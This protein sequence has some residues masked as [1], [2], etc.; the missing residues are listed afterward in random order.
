MTPEGDAA[1][2]RNAPEHTGQPGQ[3]MFLQLSRGTMRW[4]TMILVAE[5]ILS[6]TRRFGRMNWKNDRKTENTPG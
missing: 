6:S 1:M 5:E 4:G 3:F 2:G